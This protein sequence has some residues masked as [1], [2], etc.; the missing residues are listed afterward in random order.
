MKA[1]YLYISICT[2]IIGGIL[3]GLYLQS[4]IASYTLYRGG[5][6]R[7]VLPASHVTLSAVLDLGLN[8]YYI[9]GLTQDHIYISNYTAPAFLLSATLNLQDTTHI[10]LQT[11]QLD[12]I[13]HPQHFKTIVTP[14]Y[15]YMVNGAEPI[16]LQGDTTQ[17][18]ATQK[19][20]H[21]SY[22]SDLIPIDSG[23][24][25]LRYYS[26]RNASFTLGLQTPSP[27]YFIAHPELIEKQK[28]GFFSVDGMFHYSKALQKLIYVYRYRNQFFSTDLHLQLQNRYH[29][30]DTISWAKVTASEI[31]SS[32]TFVL[33]SHPA[34]T[35]KLNTVRDHFL[36]N[37]SGVMSQND[38]ADKF[39]KEDMVDVYDLTTGTYVKSFYLPRYHGNS[40][41][42]FRVIEQH[43]FTI[44]GSYLLCYNY[45]P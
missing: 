1:M 29:T 38:N 45:T 44:Q 24:F 13:K 8:S 25:V 28:E 2:V 34:V 15:F 11:D 18:K 12:Q 35:Q 4:P 30:L 21:L 6:Q 20:G 16:I 40:V 36:Y 17:W 43:I 7:T 37:I 9:S 33:L 22:F 5:F 14:P 32:N 19:V 27:P 31:K 23:R 42:D 26:K 3:G 10:V 39:K 41:A